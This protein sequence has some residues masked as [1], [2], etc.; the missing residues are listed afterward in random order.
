MK[1]TI[2]AVIGTSSASSEEAAAAEHVGRLVAERGW[3]LVTGGLGGV[4][5]AASK[6]ASEAGGAVVGILPHGDSSRANAHV[7]IPIA[8][9]MG[10]ARN[11]IIAHTADALI[12]VGGAYGTLTEISMALNLGKPVFGINTWEIKGVRQMP[13]A[14]SAINACA[15]S[16]VRSGTTT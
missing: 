16:V 5:E 14:E 15:S 13:D 12:A 9:N 11:A 7:Q 10:F 8:T 6:G 1:K 2:V 4:M 3:V